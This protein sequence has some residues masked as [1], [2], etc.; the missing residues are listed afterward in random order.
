MVL[1]RLSALDT[2]FLEVETENAHMHVGWVAQ[3]DPPPSRPPGFVALRR[4]VERRLPRA[5]RYRQKLAQDPVGLSAPAWIDDETF[6]VAAHVRRAEEPT[7]REIVDRVM[8]EPLDRGRPLWELWIADRLADGRI[9]IVGKAHHSMVDGLAAV[10]LGAM[11]LDPNPTPSPSLPDRWRP[12][13][14]PSR[15]DLLVSGVRERAAAGAQLALLPAR[16]ALRPRRL[17]GVAAGAPRA[18]R[19]LARAA[20]PAMPSGLNGPI[21]RRRHL[22]SSGRP[23]DD[24]RRIKTHFGTT[25]NDVLLAASAGALG[26]LLGRG[27][28]PPP[29][30]KTMV[31]VATRDGSASELGNGISFV[32][33]DLPC[34]EPDP[35]RRLREV[36]AAMTVRKEAREPEGADTVLKAIGYAPR[37]LQRLA[38]RMVA[39]PRTFNVT[40]SNIPGPTE[41]LYMLGC[42]LREAYPVV[43]IADRHGLSI[44]MTSIGDEA[45]FGIYADGDLAHEAEAL[46]YCLEHSIDELLEVCDSKPAGTVAESLI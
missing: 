40:I 42:R 8:S 29:R 1:D 35:V 32:F 24:L 43:P 10:E 30:L 16:L 33:I 26:R 17:L 41:P 3:F 9:G 39:S 28:K 18:A 22:A 25:V 27:G 13:P 7:L 44:G 34:D 37:P 2:S 14:A 23:L 21:S 20:R 38:S 46:V 6:D 45:C 36:H 19:A 5:P 15:R 4:H 12:Q 31:P 11:L